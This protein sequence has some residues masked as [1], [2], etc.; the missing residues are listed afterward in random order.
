M[1]K[2]NAEESVYDDFA[3]YF[4]VFSNNPDMDI[5]TVRIKIDK[6]KK[7]FFFVFF[8]SFDH[9]FMYFALSIYYHL[10]LIVQLFSYFASSYFY[11]RQSY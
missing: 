9:L 8:S 10:S 2:E 4:I 5:K 11:N 1:L 3:T 6:I 7:V